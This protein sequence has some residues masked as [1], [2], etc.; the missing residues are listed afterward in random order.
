MLALQAEKGEWG[1][2]G[3]ENEGES[4][5]VIEN[6]RSK[7]VTFLLCAEVDEKKRLI[8]L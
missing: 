5:E 1:K 7:N 4:G 6:K 8:R 3:G 2:R